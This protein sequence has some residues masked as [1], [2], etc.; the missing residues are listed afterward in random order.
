MQ[1]VEPRV[2]TPF[3]FFTI[4]ELEAMRLAVRVRH[5]VTVMRS[6]SGTL[7][8]MMPIMKARLEAQYVPTMKP[9]A[10][11]RTPRKIATP[12]MMCTKWLI[13]LLMGVSEVS[14]DVVRRAIRP[15]TVASPVRTTMAMAWPLGQVVPKKARL[16][17]SN[18]LSSVYMLV[19]R[20][21]SGSPVNDELSTAMSSVAHRMRTSAGICSPYL[22]LTMSPGTSWEAS[23]TS[24]PPPRT[25][26]HT[27]GIMFLKDSIKLEAFLSCRYPNTPVI[28]TTEPNTMARAKLSTVRW[29]PYA[30]KHRA[31]PTHKRMEKKSVI[32][33]T[34]FWHSDLVF[35]GVRIFRPYSSCFAD[36]VSGVRP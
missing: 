11:N 32:C 4:T 2:S 21:A 28:K 12:E 10:K 18:G 26:V 35:G 6:P 33:S 3:K 34:N 20:M 23:M 9:R 27:S 31:Q 5:T 24:S 29:R 30:T 19:L 22:I 36:T 17:V 7:A 25:T 1:V 16:A 13:S 8:T 15:M 14:V